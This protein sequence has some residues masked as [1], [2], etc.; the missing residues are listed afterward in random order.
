MP[1]D[2]VRI[3]VMRSE[4][5]QQTTENRAVSPVIGV[6]LMVAITVILAAVIGAFVL[7]IGDQQETAPNTSFETAEMSGM[8]LNE[9][10]SYTPPRTPPN[11]KWKDINLTEVEFTHAGGD[12][13][14]RSDLNLKVNGNE[15]VYGAYALYQSANRPRNQLYPAVKET[16][17]SEAPLRKPPDWNG[18]RSEQI[19]SG[20]LFW[21]SAYGGVS[22]KAAYTCLRN[23]GGERIQFREWKGYEDW[24]YSAAGMPG[25]S[26][27]LW[28]VNFPQTGDDMSLVWE[29]SSGGKTQTL[30]KYTVQ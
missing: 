5:Y 17:G 2:Q 6:I 9:R 3:D 19:A 23:E 12:V 24:E 13:L 22:Y 25:S 20:E 27:C 26:K 28:D 1:F 16:I 14:D 8:V 18:Q 30:F 7:E 29:A 11:D 10:L 15:S 21:A 4:S